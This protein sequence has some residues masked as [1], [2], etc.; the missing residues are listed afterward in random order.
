M[1]NFGT[2]LLLKKNCCKHIDAFDSDL[3]YEVPLHNFV[4]FVEKNISSLLSFNYILII[5]ILGKISS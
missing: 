3:S 5:F 2:F 4:S 1:P